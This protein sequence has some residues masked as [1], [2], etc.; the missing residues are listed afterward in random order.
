MV[1]DTS[2]RQVDETLRPDEYLKMAANTKIVEIWQVCTA[3]NISIR[4]DRKVSFGSDIVLGIKFSASLFRR[5]SFGSSRIPPPQQRWGK[6]IAWRAKGTSAKEAN[7]RL[8]WFDSNRPPHFFKNKVWIWPVFACFIKVCDRGV[9]NVLLLAWFE[10][11]VHERRCDKSRTHNITGC[12]VSLVQTLSV[13][14]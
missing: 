5:R 2:V 14:V 7:F 6:K 4:R 1:L 8:R 3:I 13:F 11:N 10:V 9:V 12:G